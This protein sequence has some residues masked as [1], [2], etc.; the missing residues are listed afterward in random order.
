M[1][2]DGGHA[3]RGGDQPAAGQPLPAPAGRMP[4][5]PR[6][7]DGALCG[8]L[9]RPVQQPRRSGRRPRGGSGLGGGQWPRPAPGQDAS[10]GLPPAGPRL[11]VPGLQVRSGPAMGAQEE[12]GPPQGQDQGEDATHARGQP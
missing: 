6:L 5:G 7:P 3:A 4:G 9:R 8:R 2:A 10:R 11:R 12:P 1:D